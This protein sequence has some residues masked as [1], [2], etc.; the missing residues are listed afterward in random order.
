M[1]YKDAFGMDVTYGVGEAVDKNGGVD[2]THFGA[3]KQV[4]LNWNYD[5]EGIPSATELT[6]R[7]SKI[8]AG[9]VIVSARLVV[10]KAAATAATT[11][12][13]GLVKLNNA[14]TDP[15]VIDTD[16]LIDGGALAAGI[17]TG[18]GDL[19][20]KPVGSDD[21]YLAIAPS[22]STDAALGGLEAVLIVEYV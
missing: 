6:I 11:V 21:G 14:A 18:A 8:P 19:I 9:S 3:I 7:S 22:A 13:V 2:V 15:H 4:Q 16:G 1:T 10:L 20:G 12:D 17:V 5:K